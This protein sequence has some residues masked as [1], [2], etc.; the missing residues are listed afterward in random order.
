MTQQWQESHHRSLQGY[1]PAG[2][3]CPAQAAA[4]AGRT[5]SSLSAQG[6]AA[7]R[8]TNCPRATEGGGGK[9]A[10]RLVFVLLQDPPLHGLSSW[11][12]SSLRAGLPSE[13]CCPRH[14]NRGSRAPLLGRAPFLPSCALCPGGLRT[15]P[16]AQ[17]PVSL[18]GSG[19]QAIQRSSFFLTA[20]L[21]VKTVNSAGAVTVNTHISSYPHISSSLASLFQKFLELFY[22]P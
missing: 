20:A 14:R 10:N 8:L 17:L 5:H 6:S 22:R 3:C 1:P 15:I 21:K 12:G 18:P 9:A 4:R 2:L 16:Q 7:R 19:P 13:K 11:F